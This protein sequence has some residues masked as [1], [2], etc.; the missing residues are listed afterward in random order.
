MNIGE[1]KRTPTLA[2]IYCALGPLAS[3]LMSST[4][5]LMNLKKEETKGEEEEN[6]DHRSSEIVLDKRKKI[7]VLL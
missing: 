1:E 7:L 3:L 4:A 2:T 6:G 5:W